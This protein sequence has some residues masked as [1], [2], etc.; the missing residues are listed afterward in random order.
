MDSRKSGFVAKL[1]HAGVAEDPHGSAVTP[2]YQT[3]TFGFR[4]A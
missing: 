4:N 1:V 2:I 3:S